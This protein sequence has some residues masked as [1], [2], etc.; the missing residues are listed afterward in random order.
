VRAA[1]VA[2]DRREPRRIGAVIGQLTIGGA[3]NQLVELVRGLDRNRFAPFVYSLAESAGPV[4]ERLAAAGVPVRVIGSVG[5]ERARRLAQ[6]LR[7]DRIELVHSWL[8]IANTYAW[9]A[10]LRGA[11]LPLVTSARN[12]KSQGWGHHLANV[13]A[14]RVSARII[15][16]SEQ[17][18]E[19][20]ARRYRAP[21]R[22]LEVIYNGVDTER[23]RPGRREG[24]AAPTIVT[25]G[26][27]VAQ[28]NPRLFVDAAARLRSR[29]PE[30]RFVMLG[31]GPLRG[32]ILARA[33]AAGLNGSL[34]LPGERAD[35]ENVLNEADVFW[36]TS[37]W[38]GLPNVVMEAMACGLPVVATDVGGTRELFA[39]GREGF[40]VR[41]GRVDDL[42]H[43]GGALLRD[44][45]LRQSMG[46]AARRRAEQFSVR[47]MVR[48]TEGVYATALGEKP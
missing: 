20:V 12:C 44:A 48:A 7:A 37:S 23:F 25:A 43:Y 8:F 36:L 4:R 38:E 31:E 34:A 2:E 24:G 16:N 32:E 46:E 14:F 17:V 6:A 1:S 26:R 35:L 3:E 22:L 40:L 29:F 11:R 10:C 21:R 9:A 45:T 47:R 28:K 42:V 18:R 15:V 13:A 30:A 27:L 39:S 5:L 19:Y 41:P 33:A